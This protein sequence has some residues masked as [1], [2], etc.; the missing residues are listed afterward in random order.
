MRDD[1]KPKINISEHIYFDRGC[2]T[3]NS[4][5]LSFGGVFPIWHSQTLVSYLTNLRI[6]TFPS[7]PR[8][9]SPNIPSSIA[10]APLRPPKKTPPNLTLSRLI[11][12]S[13]FLQRRQ[14]VIMKRKKASKKKKRHVQPVVKG[15]TNHA[16]HLLSF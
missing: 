3:A 1:V 6:N 5:A 13:G 14:N 16:N 10:S 11:V 8:A 4:I 9:A 2:S 12:H 7:S 15:G